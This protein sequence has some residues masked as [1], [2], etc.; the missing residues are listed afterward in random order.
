[1]SR[2]SLRRLLPAPPSRLHMGKETDSRMILY[3]RYAADPGLACRG[4][5]PSIASCVHARYGA[6]M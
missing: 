6:D 5:D 4:T 3:A 2:A 1:M